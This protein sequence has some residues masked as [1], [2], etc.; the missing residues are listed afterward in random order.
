MKLL[1]WLKIY[2]LDHKFVIKAARKECFD[3]EFDRVT[4]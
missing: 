3:S 4:V 1:I 2:A